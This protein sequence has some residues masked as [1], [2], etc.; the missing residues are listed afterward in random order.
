MESWWDSEVLAC[1]V[2]ARAVS[3]YGLPISGAE[4]AHRFLGLSAKDMRGLLEADLGR[5]LPPDHEARCGEELFGLFRRELK[6]VAGIRDVLVEIEREEMARC[7]ASSSAPER[8]ALAL[9]VTGLSDFFGH[10]F[11]APPW[12]RA[13]SPRPTFSYMRRPRWGFALRVALWSRIA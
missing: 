2:Q 3:G 1:E 11:S 8:I 12:S 7:V 9:K 13:G 4:V 5:P 10:M 6:P